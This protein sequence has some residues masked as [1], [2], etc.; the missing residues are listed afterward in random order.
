MTQRD[1][2]NML[3]EGAK[4]ILRALYQSLPNMNNEQAKHGI[5][6]A[7][8]LRRC[9]NALNKLEATTHPTTPA[10]PEVPHL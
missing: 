6:A 5:T 3:S 8:A 7:T 4:E 1:Q 10:P 9:T 2:I